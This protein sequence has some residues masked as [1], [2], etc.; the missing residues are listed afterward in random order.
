MADPDAP[1]APAA[2]G[3]LSITDRLEL[4]LAVERERT[5]QAQM[6][7]AQLQLQLAQYKLD[8]EKNR[9][10]QAYNLRDGDQIDPVSGRITRA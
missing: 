3:E 4:A 7:N 6:A 9:I 10:K 1:N 8:G 5:A 2:T